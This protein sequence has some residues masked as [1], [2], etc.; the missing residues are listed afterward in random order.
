MHTTTTQFHSLCTAEA[1]DVYQAGVVALEADVLSRPSPPTLP[2]I[3]Y[4]LA[5]FT[6]LL[7]QVSARL[8]VVVVCR[9]RAIRCMR[10]Q[11]AGVQMLCS[12]ASPLNPGWCGPISHTEVLPTKPVDHQCTSSLTSCTPFKTCTPAGALPCVRGGHWGRPRSQPH[13]HHHHKRS[14]TRGREAGPSHCLSKHLLHSG[15]RG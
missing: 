1:L 2:A 4:H 12:C 8:Y 11:S 13:H 3:A 6:E 5:S 15:K 7:P 14:Q 10:L 9:C